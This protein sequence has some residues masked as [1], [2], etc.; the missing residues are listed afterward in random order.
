MLDRNVT[1]VIKNTTEVTSSLQNVVS[2]ATAWNLLDSDFVYIGFRGKFASRHFQMSVANATTS[3]VSVEYWNGTA[4]TA[5]LDVVDQTQGF[6]QDGWISWVNK[7]DWKKSTQTP[8][9]DV[10]L[11]WVRVSVSV[12]LDAPTSLQSCVNLFS[13]D[14][15]L[16]V[17]YP[18]LVSDSRYL[19]D[20]RT[21]F[22]EQH[23]AGRDK[24]IL[25]LKQRRTISDEAQIID[26]NEVA[27][28]AAHAA[29]ETILRPI[30]QGREI[31]KRAQEDFKNEINELTKAIDKN[32]DGVVSDKERSN[33]TR[34]DVVRR[35]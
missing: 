10:E 22:L 32:K 13:D 27:V 29:A 14:E 21:N 12:S 20:S 9:V 31:F 6:K 4:W 25:R 35:G 26:I 33:F 34:M 16:R 15:L 3:V 8:V 5:V 18:E 2:D 17:Y 28:A 11:Y 24:V 30:S 1:R 7:G 23:V 19:P